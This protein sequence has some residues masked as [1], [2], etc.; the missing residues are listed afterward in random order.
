MTKPGGDPSAAAIEAVLDALD[1]F[2][3]CLEQVVPLIRPRLPKYLLDNW[4]TMLTGTHA[5]CP[6]WWL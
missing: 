3:L 1:R 4:R 5:E 6:P 2:D